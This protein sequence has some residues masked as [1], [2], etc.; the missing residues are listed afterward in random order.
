[1]STVMLSLVFLVLLPVFAL[2]VRRSDPVRRRLHDGNTYWEDP[3][4]FEPTLDR[5]RRMF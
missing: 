5:M 1:M 3:S 4:P 2:I